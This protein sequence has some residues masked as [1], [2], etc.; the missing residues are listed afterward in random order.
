MRR[1]IIE[2]IDESGTIE[3][4]TSTN[5][6]QCRCQS[7]SDWPSHPSRIILRSS[8]PS[9]HKMVSRFQLT[10]W[11]FSC[12]SLLST[13]LQIGSTPSIFRPQKPKCVYFTGAGMYFW[14]Q[15]G[16]AKYIQQNCDLSNMPVIGA[17]AGSLTATVSAI[18]L[19]C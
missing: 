18:R 4:Y 13:C 15:A 5:I 17:S 12:C 11:V 16:A 6:V 19:K 3:T 8:V 9:P 2:R 14:W 1:G 10:L 7:S